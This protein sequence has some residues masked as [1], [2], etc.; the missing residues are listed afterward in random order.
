MTDFERA[1]IA[2]EESCRRADEDARRSE[3]SAHRLLSLA[4]VLRNLREA[5][6]F[7]QLFQ[8][9]YGRGHRE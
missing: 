7:D 4:A 5:N 6:G 3:E 2:A 9:A 8:D 1:A